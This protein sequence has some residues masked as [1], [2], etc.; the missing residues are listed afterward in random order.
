MIVILYGSGMVA[1][2][3]YYSRRQTTTRDYF[4]AGGNMG[5][6]VIGI[7]LVATLLSPIS[8][9]A[10]PGEMIKNGPVILCGIV[11]TPITFV[12]VGFCLIE[13]RA[14]GHAHR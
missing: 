8:Y 13:H 3:L 7:S 6:L 11:A 10:V 5:P 14:V 9:L 12:V 4:V 2:G 1:L